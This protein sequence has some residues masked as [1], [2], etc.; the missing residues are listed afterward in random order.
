[1]DLWALRKTIGETW[2]E[3]W[4]TLKNGPY[5]H[6]GFGEV[7]SVEGH[8]LEHKSHYFRSVLT[9]DIDVSLEFG[10]SLDSDRREV[11][12]A[13]FG[14]DFTFPDESIRRE[15][16]DIFYRGALVDRSLTR[17]PGHLS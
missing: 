3:H 9:S 8:Y 4:H 1:M 7:E 17:F 5:F 15:F 11:T 16:I 10:M 6:D 13:G 12:I 2:D 14:W